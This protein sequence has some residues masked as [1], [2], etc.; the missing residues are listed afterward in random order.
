METIVRN[1]KLYRAGF[2]DDPK[3]IE[4]INFVEEILNKVKPK[5]DE[6]KYPNNIFYFIEE[7]LYIQQDLKNRTFWVCY[8]NFWSI[9]GTKYNLKPKEI[10]VLLNHL[11]EEHFKCRDYTTKEN[12]WS[13]T[14][15]FEEH[16]KC[17]DY[18]TR[19]LLLMH[20]RRFEEHFKCRDYTTKN[21]WNSFLN[22]LEEHFKC[23]D[24]TTKS[25][26]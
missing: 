19:S 15:L 2:N 3:L 17:R 6:E 1:I 12:R 9:F 20:K 7:Q 21:D 26:I 22:T 24:Y 14:I 10:Q 5:V 16:F 11:F 13:S 4:M 8:N 25:F 23:R 18:T